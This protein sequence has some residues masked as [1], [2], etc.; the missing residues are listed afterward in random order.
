MDTTVV[1]VDPGVYELAVQHFKLPRNFTPQLRDAKEYVEDAKRS[2]AQFDYIVHDVFTGGVEPVDLFTLEFMRGL[3]DILAD[4]GA[5]S[6]VSP[7]Y[8]CPTDRKSIMHQLTSPQTK[9]YAGDLSFPLAGQVFRTI[10]SVFPSCRI[11]RESE[12]KSD[13]YEGDFTNTVVFCKK[14]AA[15]LKFRQ[16][17]KGDF[18][19]TKSRETYLFPKWEVDS[20]V[21]EQ[22]GEETQSLLEAGKLS[23][24]QSWQV[25]GALGHWEIM[26]NVI[27]AVYWENW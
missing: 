25:K 21:F 10:L 11:F 20:A 9:N 8:T 5:I 24:L 17:V 18:L 2:G 3:H 13:M 15:P 6:I 27:P 22:T 7:S 16:P 1:E 12:G 19:G 23:Q 14:S 4:D 26:R